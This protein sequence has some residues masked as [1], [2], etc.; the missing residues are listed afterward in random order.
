MSF[1]TP[2]CGQSSELEGSSNEGLSTDSKESLTTTTEEN[3]ADTSATTLSEPN[4]E[5]SIDSTSNHDIPDYRTTNR[6]HSLQLSKL[7]SMNLSPEELRLQDYGNTAD[8]DQGGSCTLPA[9]RQRYTPLLELFQEQLSKLGTNT[10]EQVVDAT[11]TS[12]APAPILAK[13]NVLEP[14]TGHEEGSQGPTTAEPTSTQKLLQEA[15]QTPVAAVPVAPRMSIPEEGLADSLRSI[16]AGVGQISAALQQTR[17]EL[18]A[19]LNLARQDFPHGIQ[20]AVKAGVAAIDALRGGPAQPTAQSASTTTADEATQAPERIENELPVQETVESWTPERIVNR[21]RIWY[22]SYPKG[23]QNEVNEVNEVTEIAEV[24]EYLVHYSGRDSSDDAWCE[25]E[26]IGV[27]RLIFDYEHE[28]LNKILKMR[29][30]EERRR[31]LTNSA[32]TFFAKYGRN[33]LVA[34]NPNI[35]SRMLPAPMLENNANNV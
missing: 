32:Y 11:A 35:R 12:R 1:N 16:M 2:F 26:Q 5:C 8:G 10:L 19:T 22:D 20:D 14:A 7:E 27:E 30:A 18:H 31:T 6:G 13:A 29:E 9:Q 4:A 33:R 28:Y 24:S 15:L 23:T 34:E 25:K 3:L 21:R 17:A